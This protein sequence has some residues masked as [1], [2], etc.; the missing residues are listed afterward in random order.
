VGWVRDT[1]NSTII[2]WKSN[3]IDSKKFQYYWMVKFLES[4]LEFDKQDSFEMIVDRPL[5]KMTLGLNGPWLIQPNSDFLD[6]CGSATDFCV[7]ATQSCPLMI[8][9][10]DSG[11][12]CIGTCSQVEPFWILSKVFF[13]NLGTSA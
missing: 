2:E 1:L 7:I 13:I 3:I 12:I 9:A 6:S 5:Q 8:V 4:L 11:C 10:Y